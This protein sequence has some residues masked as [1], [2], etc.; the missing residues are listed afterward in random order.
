MSSVRK[1]LKERE[2][3]VE[4]IPPCDCRNKQECQLEGKQIRGTVY[5]CNAN[6][7]VNPDKLHLGNADGSFK[8]RFYNHGTSLLQSTSRR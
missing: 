7:K 6:T 1:Y 4:K 3:N 8:K 5:K 2:E